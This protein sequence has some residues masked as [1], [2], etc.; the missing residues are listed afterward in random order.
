MAKQLIKALFF[1]LA[2]CP[3][4]VLAID[5][6]QIGEVLYHPEKTS[7]MENGK[8]YKMLVTKFASPNSNYPVI[9]ETIEALKKVFGKDN[10]Q[11]Q[12][13][14]GE[15]TDIADAD[16]VLSSAGTFSRMKLNGARDLA[17]VASKEF[18][19]PNRAEGSVFI[20]LKR[21]SDLQ[22][23]EDL[24]GKVLATTGPNA[25][26]GYHVALGEIFKRGYDPDNFFAKRVSTGHDME[27]VLKFL[28]EGKAEVGIVRTC[29]IEELKKLG[30]NVA[31]I[32]VVAKDKN[33]SD[34]LQCVSSTDLYPNWTIFATPR[35]SSQDA[36]KVSL[37]LL[38]FP[39]NSTKPYWSIVS[40]FS[41]TDDLYKNLKLGPYEYLRQW[42]WK[43]LWEK[44]GIF[45]S[46][47]LFFIFA[48]IAH[49]LRVTYLV[50]KRT[51]QLRH[52]LQ[53][54]KESEER[55]QEAQSKIRT[56][57]KVGAIGQ[58]SSIIAHELRQPLAT[59]MNYAHGLQRLLEQNANA[60]LISDGIS[61]MQRQAEKAE[62]I[63]SKV[64]AYA[65]SEGIQRR[66]LDLKD[67]TFSSVNL[68]NDSKISSIPVRFV[69]ER[70]TPVWINGDP[71]EIELCIVNLIKN[72]LDASPSESWVNVSVRE[73][74]DHRNIRLAV[75][76]V[77]DYG[78]RLSD[79]Q[80]E[81]LSEPLQSKK[82][83]G[84]GLGLAIVKL[85]IANHKGKLVFQRMEKRG[86]QAQIYLPVVE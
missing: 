53:L 16:L 39:E 8:V 35:L 48:L 12:V 79:E 17:T 61:K 75:F 5:S 80:F 74:K 27:N 42:T 6:P 40:D 66:K 21:R 33:A 45:F 25:F 54:L 43:G 55:A 37:A 7:G 41:S 13:Y 68:I 38:S 19:D 70:N 30:G 62:T 4:M 1:V 71:V 10:L 29:F 78:P 63:V 3:T 60:D 82:I 15:T 9:E 73:E 47:V 67:L 77:E 32:R 76:Q 65:K 18:P 64:R 50:D 22:D 52:S 23:F 26:S 56:L 72:A 86:I 36:R 44:Y 14:S 84:L 46:F 81:T 20:V 58:I 34:H 59:I 24:K 49:S 51:S 69:S 31:D 83:E 85:I 11:V 57:Q 2:F 28:R